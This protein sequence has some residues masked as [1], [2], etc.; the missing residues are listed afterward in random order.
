MNRLK[1]LS[2]FL[3]LFYFEYSYVTKLSEGPV[4]F[5]YQTLN[6]WHLFQ[7]DK[8]AQATQLFRFPTPHFPIEVHARSA[9]VS[10]AVPRMLGYCYPFYISTKHHLRADVC[11]FITINS[12]SNTGIQLPELQYQLLPKPRMALISEN[13]SRL[14]LDEN[15]RI[16]AHHIRIRHKLQS[17]NLDNTG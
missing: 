14:I 12:S 2:H 5:F 8:V 6:W 4:H 16:K 1:F 11:M 15:R 17:R 10:F 13:N 9:S 7:G 3:S